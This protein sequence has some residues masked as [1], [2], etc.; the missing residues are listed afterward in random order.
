METGT[1]SR[2][3]LLL[4]FKEFPFVSLYGQMKRN[5]YFDLFFVVCVCLIFL[6]REFGF[7][8]CFLRALQSYGVIGLG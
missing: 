1:G 5:G 4:V 8:S 7:I 6:A 3:D 2:C